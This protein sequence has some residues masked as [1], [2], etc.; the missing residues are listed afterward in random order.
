MCNHEICETRVQNH[1]DKIDEMKY[2]KHKDLHTKTFRTAAFEGIAL[3]FFTSDSLSFT[4]NI[5]GT[6]LLVTRKM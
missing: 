5:F 6:L 4:Q 3:K 2:Y 1:C